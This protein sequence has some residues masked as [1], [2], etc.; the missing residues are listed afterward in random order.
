MENLETNS[1]TSS[2]K[3]KK[4][5]NIDW[6]LRVSTRSSLGSSQSYSLGNSPKASLPRCTLSFTEKPQSIHER[7]IT[8]RKSTNKVKNFHSEYL[9]YGFWPDIA[10]K[11]QAKFKTELR[12]VKQRLGQKKKEV[13]V[14]KKEVINA[15]DSC[16][17]CSEL[18]KKNESTQLA[19]KQAIELSTLLL[20]E[21]KKGSKLL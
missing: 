1:T 7:P 10:P 8:E 20:S 9:E 17:G 19:L 13:K 2:E 3:G 18:R 14:L 5:K 12:N 11:D 6:P 16:L 21:M 15:R 4:C